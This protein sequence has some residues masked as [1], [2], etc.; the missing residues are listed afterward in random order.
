MSVYDSQFRNYYALTKHLKGLIWATE[1]LP[2][3]NI[4]P[5]IVRC[6]D[7]D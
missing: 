3:E 4:E 2:N 7:D 1:N 6:G 5:A